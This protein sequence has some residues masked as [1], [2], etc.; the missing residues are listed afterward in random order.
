MIKHSAE[1]WQIVKVLDQGVVLKC[2]QHFKLL[3]VF[4][5]FLVSPYYKIALLVAHF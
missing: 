3:R 4:E 2:D 1:T 5:V